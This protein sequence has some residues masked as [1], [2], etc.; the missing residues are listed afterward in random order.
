MRPQL[1]SQVT[2]VSELNHFCTV[3]VELKGHF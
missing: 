3:E 2:G 1:D